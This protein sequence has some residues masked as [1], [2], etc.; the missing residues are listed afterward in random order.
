MNRYNP[1]GVIIDRAV[2]TNLMPPWEAGDGTYAL[3]SSSRAGHPVPPAIAERA[4]SVFEDNLQDAKAGRYGWTKKDAR[5]LTRIVAAI[6]RAL[7]A[8][9]NPGG[10]VDAVKW[11][12]SRRNPGPRGEPDIKPFM[13]WSGYAVFGK[14]V[15]RHPSI[16]NVTVQEKPTGWMLF[17]GGVSYGPWKS[18]RAAVTALEQGTFAPGT[19]GSRNNPVNARGGWQNT[20][21]GTWLAHYANGPSFVIEHDA[22]RRPYYTL[23]QGRWSKKTNGMA[24]L[25]NLGGYLTLGEAKQ[26]AES[27]RF[28][29]NRA[30]EDRRD[31]GGWK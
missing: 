5:D 20:Q 21:P 6:K 17:V 8:K 27:A 12:R 14:K 7:S 15:Y 10:Y 1:E 23:Y 29:W 3:G 18:A 9:K 4:L 16:P 26:A 24:G 31:A 13:G 30:R 25:V 19:G 28:R 11:S 2:A 22:S